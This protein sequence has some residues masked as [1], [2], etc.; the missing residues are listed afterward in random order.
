MITICEECGKKYKVDPDKIAGTEAKFK[1]KTCG[2]LITISHPAPTIES[3][4]PM[5]SISP[6]LKA[7]EAA[8]LKPI[9]ASP[10]TDESVKK[11]KRPAF[12]RPAK[13]RLGLTA[14]LFM[15][16]IIVSLVPLAM[17]WGLTL[18]QTKERMRNDTKRRIN[19]TSISITSHVEDWVDKNAGI[20]KTL[21]NMEDIIAME[22][23]K[24]EPLLETIRRIYPWIY[25]TVTIDVD[26]N[27]IARND[28]RP[29]LNYSNRQYFK[30]I[31]AGKAITWYTF[32]DGLSQKPTLLLAVPIIRYDEIVGVIAN[33]ISLNDV[34][35][36]KVTWEF[37]KTGFAFMVNNKGKVIAHK[38]K[39][40]IL[41]QKNLSHHPLI[42]AFK[43][44]HRGSVSFTQDGKSLLGRA[45]G[46][47]LGWIVALQQEEKEAFFLIDQMMSYAY[48]LLAVTIVFVFII[49]WFSGRALSRPIIRLT[50]AADRIS[51]GELEVKI[52][53][54]RKD[55]IGD[56]AEAIARMQDS[57]RLS[58]ERLRQRR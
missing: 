18:K 58:I 23:L 56:L 10:A 57:I 52:D 47:A 3:K 50:D 33:A 30:D 13:S 40:Y 1:C 39:S 21:A 15:M 24:Q 46:T 34:S 55:E 41:Q 44:G 17:F 11:D 53:T 22:R 14:K 32:I 43:K 25:R 42:A 12:T 38:N 5:P 2:H 51:V 8:E 54:Q 31:M 26:G 7:Q 36:R 37:D 4:Q 48:L 16:M 49:A 6:E 27:N 29:L 19:Q 45:R 35:K 20:L 28:G 9:K